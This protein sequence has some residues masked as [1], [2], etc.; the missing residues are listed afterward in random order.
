MRLTLPQVDLE[1]NRT[2]K[3]NLREGL[4]IE[5]GFSYVNYHP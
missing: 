3:V 4:E 2:S 5:R 1:D